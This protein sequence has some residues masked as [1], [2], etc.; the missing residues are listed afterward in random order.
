M[1]DDTAGM[2]FVAFVVGGIPGGIAG[3]L[4][5]FYLD[6]IWYINADPLSGLLMVGM[7]CGLVMVVVLYIESFALA[8]VALLLFPIAGW[9]TLTTWERPSTPLFAPDGSDRTVEMYSLSWWFEFPVVYIIFLI[10]SL[11]IFLLWISND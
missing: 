7:L 5:S 1:T 3:F 8:L 11:I 9:F 2:Y 6:S 10:I 4:L